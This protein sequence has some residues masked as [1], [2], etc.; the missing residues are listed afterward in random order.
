[1]NIGTVVF[2]LVNRNKFF[3]GCSILYGNVLAPFFEFIHLFIESC[4]CWKLL[5][6]NI[7]RSIIQIGTHIC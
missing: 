1:M 2:A 3:S 4:K 7:N 6:K 5:P